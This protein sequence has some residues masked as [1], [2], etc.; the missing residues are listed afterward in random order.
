VTSRILVLVLSALALAGVPAG[1]AAGPAP[2]AKGGELQVSLADHGSVTF[3]VPEGWV[4][5]VKRQSPSTPPTVSFDPPSGERFNVQITV[6][7]KTPDVPAFDPEHL[8]KVVEQSRDQAAQGATIRGPGLKEVTG[9][10][11]HGWCYSAMD[12]HSKA[13]PGDWKYMT[14]GAAAFPDDLLLTF[15]ILSNDPGEPE[16]ALALAMIRTSKYDRA[17]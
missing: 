3:Q 16:A 8:R 5:Q 7:W 9:E 10:A 4:S 13:Q 2:G 1:A 12:E 14:Q 15:T 11:V 17:Q 6:I